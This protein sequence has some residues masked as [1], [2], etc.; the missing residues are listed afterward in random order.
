LLHKNAAIDVA[1]DRLEADIFALRPGGG[2]A[3]AT[4]GEAAAAEGG[5]G[6]QEAEDYQSVGGAF[7]TRRVRGC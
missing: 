6:R 1:C 4:G 5:E 3:V 2:P 7:K